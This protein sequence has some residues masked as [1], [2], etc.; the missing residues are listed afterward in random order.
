MHHQ[1]IFYV[2]QNLL[3]LNHSSFF[4]LFNKYILNYYFLK[5]QK[6]N[7]RNN[8]TDVFEIVLDKQDIFF[9]DLPFHNI[10]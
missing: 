1:L 7:R 8:I 9:V 10:L 3:F 4:V 6:K 5:D 2:L